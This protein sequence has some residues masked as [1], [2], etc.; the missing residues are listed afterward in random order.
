VKLLTIKEYYNIHNLL[1]FYIEANNNKFRIND[2]DFPYNYFQSKKKLAD[3]E[4][5]LKRFTPSNKDCYLLGKTYHVKKNY[6]YCKDNSKNSKWE[7][8]IKFND[9][10]TQINY[11]GKLK[12]FENIFYPNLFPQELLLKP[13]IEIKL[14]Q[15]SCILLHAGG[16]SK[17]GECIIFV[18]RGSSHK[19][20]I[21]LD[22]IRNGGY[23]YLA[24]DQIIIK[25]KSVYSY[26]IH[27]AQFSYMYEYMQNEKYKNILEKIKVINYIRQQPNYQNNIPLTK[28][29]I[30]NK[31][32]FI[33]V[34]NSNEFSFEELNVNTAL[35]KL[36]YN[37]ILDMYTLGNKTGLFLK[38]M[39]I[40]SSLFGN[41]PLSSHWE[42]FTFQVRKIIQ[43]IPIYEISIPK[44]YSLETFKRIHEFIK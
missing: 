37:N 38:Y 5:R 29:A 11:Y 17:H 43:N 27:I 39:K 13:M 10:K 7:I 21:I 6:F 40:Y 26:P 20:S 22:L 24:D 14:L 18:G 44:K 15:K 42:L 9:L 35:Q 1:S 32:L 33:T 16:V 30:L 31:I 19:T 23:N 36:L 12:G 34:N 2:I 4:L 41:N 25:N 8:E 28:K 3:I